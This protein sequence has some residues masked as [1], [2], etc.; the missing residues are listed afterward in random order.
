MVNSECDEGEDDEEDDD[1][2][3]DYIV[4]LETHFERLCVWVWEK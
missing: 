2:Y 1:Y 4:F 3:G